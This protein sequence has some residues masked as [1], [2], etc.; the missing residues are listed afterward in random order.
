MGATE[1]EIWA[2]NEKYV[3]KWFAWQGDSATVDDYCLTTRG[4]IFTQPGSLDS[5]FHALFN[6]VYFVGFG[7]T[8]VEIW[9]KNEKSVQKWCSWQ[10]NRATLDDYC[11]ITRGSISTS[12]GPL[13]SSGHALFNEAFV[14][15]FGSI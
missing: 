15:R 4:Q 6:E 9:A 2:K 8:K 13:D 11:L 1:V 3:Q 7:S 14:G 10:G 5:S 12:L